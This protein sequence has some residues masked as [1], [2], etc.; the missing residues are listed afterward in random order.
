MMW[1]ALSVRPYHAEDADAALLDATGGGDARYEQSLHGGVE[2][3]F[4]VAVKQ[5][6][7]VVHVVA[8][9]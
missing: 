9:H 3:G 2:S 8:L 1:Q 5:G 7:A 4:R 6:L